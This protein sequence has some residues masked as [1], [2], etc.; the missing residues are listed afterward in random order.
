MVFQVIH[1]LTYFVSHLFPSFVKLKEAEKSDW[2]T[3]VGSNVHAAIAVFL[4]G[5]E[6][7]TNK[8]MNEDFFHV[9]PWAIITII[10]MTGY[11]VNDMIIVLYWNKAWG[12]FLPMVLHHAVGITLFPLLIWYRCA[13]A[14][15]CYAAITES[16]TPFINARWYLSSM[17]YKNSIVYTING[18]LIA[19]SWFIVR[20]LGVVYMFFVAYNT[21]WND[22]WSLPLPLSLYICFGYGVAGFL[23]V[24]WFSK[25]MKGV[26]K[27]LSKQ[28]PIEKK[29]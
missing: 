16:T 25:I 14:L 19:L 4:A 2:S 7:L 5:R 13:F 17:G 3:R 27:V 23:N 12:D 24:L 6:L 10:I 29:D 28:K 21:Y 8:E 1:R 22:L 26:M 18:L 20:I 11:F 15:Y 9:S